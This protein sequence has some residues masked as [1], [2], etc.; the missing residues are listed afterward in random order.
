M[1]EKFLVKYDLPALLLI[2][3][4]CTMIV[5]CADKEQKKYSEAE[6]R[7]LLKST[8]MIIF[9]CIQVGSLV[10]VNIYLCSFLR[11]LRIFESDV[12]LYEGKLQKESNEHSVNVSDDTGMTIRIT[13]ILPKREKM[14]SSEIA[15]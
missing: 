10:L 2:T 14:N 15:S 11:K 3:T 1:K 13:T 12:E 5:F 8:R 6:V 7:E 9:T 4:G